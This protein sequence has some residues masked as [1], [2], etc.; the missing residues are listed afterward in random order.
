M[1]ITDLTLEQKSILEKYG[2]E[3]QDW[4]ITDKGNDTQN[5]HREHE[6][7]FKDK[8]SE[9]NLENLQEN[10]LHLQNV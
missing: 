2:K 4:K 7:F 9:Y 8:L 6:R 3:F 1:V 5:I 10:E